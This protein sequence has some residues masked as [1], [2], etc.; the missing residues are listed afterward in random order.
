MPPPSAQSGYTFEDFLKRLERSPTS[1][2][3]PLYQDHRALFVQRPD[4]FTK[5]V[6]SIQWEK[7]LGL[8]QA[9]YYSQPITADTYRAV[10]ARMLLHNRHVREHK[11][12]T[13]VSWRA[14]LHVFSEAV[15]AHGA[16]LPTRMHVSALRLLAPARQWLAAIRVLQLGQ[17]N[18]QL[19]KPMLVDAAAVCANWVA[20]QHALQLLMHVHT[21]DPLLLTESIQSLRPP[22]T[23]ALSEGQAPS[24]NA[25]YGDGT[26]PGAPTA[27]QMH[28]LRT[29][30]EV[31][32][33]VPPRVALQHPLCHSF[34]TH[35]MASTSLAP[36]VKAQLLTAAVD[37]LPWAAALQML[38]VYTEPNLLEDE[39]WEGVAQLGPSAAPAT[40]AGKGRG[41]GRRST[42]PRWA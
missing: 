29:L 32:A 27:P 16:A 36:D 14:A 28:I 2:M 6:M 38:M 4:M 1:H 11:S 25:L 41:E 5:A 40:K 35:L 7:A 17:A 24:H 18:D 20:W 30:N 31:V 26:L 21:H 12:G 22:G 9:A 39:E 8:V 37:R 3:A 10:L 34:L 13:C 23:D 15:I 19:T 33:A 42:R